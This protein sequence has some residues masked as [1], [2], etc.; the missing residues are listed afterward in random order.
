MSEANH[1]EPTHAMT[2]ADFAPMKKPPE[3]GL[4]FADSAPVSNGSEDWPRRAAD[5]IKRIRLQQ[6]LRRVPKS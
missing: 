5:R 1:E 4:V 6:A 3:G 2:L